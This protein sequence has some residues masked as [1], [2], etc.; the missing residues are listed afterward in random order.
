MANF[1]ADGLV[2][3][4][5]SDL[6]G[7]TLDQG[8]ITWLTEP[9]DD[10]QTTLTVADPTKLRR[11]VAEVGEELVFVDTSDNNGVT[12]APFGRGYQATEA[13][14]HPVHTRVAFSPRYPRAKVR[15]TINEVIQGVWPMLFALGEAIVTPAGGR[16]TYELPADVEGDEGVLNVR[17]EVAGISKFWRTL[18]RYRV[19]L[20]ADTDTGRSIDILEPLD[21]N[22]V[23]IT[24]TR[25]PQALA[26]D[27]EW[28]DTGLAE[29]AWPCVR[30]GAM[31][32]MIAPGES[33]MAG[34][35][36]VRASAAQS[37]RAISPVA[38]SR[39]YYAVYQQ[40]LVEE[41]LRLLN[42]VEITNNREEF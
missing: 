22:P 28:A 36:S 31:H 8:Q 14:A 40:L 20:D 23:K 7:Y 21:F 34:L 24:Y 12:L 26:A 27:G 5:L 25:R 4:L 6:S 1:T 37:S 33:G 10:A 39:Q 13:S 16:I 15:Q 30:Y 18:T 17:Q 11:G 35:N 41:R 42:D 2:E 32:L 38:L 19:N 3:H 9:V 29:S